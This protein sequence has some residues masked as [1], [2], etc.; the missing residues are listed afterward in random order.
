MS[1]ELRTPLNAVIGFSEMME[2]QLLG[3]LGNDKYL[4]YVSGIRKSGEHLLSLISDILDMSKIEA[5]KYDLSLESFNLSKSARLAVHMIEGRALNENVKVIINLQSEDLNIVADRRAV[6]QVMLNLLSNAVKFSNKGGEVTLDV[7]QNNDYT[8]IEASDSG[9]GI[10]A[11]KLASI[12]EP[13]EQAEGHLSREYEGTGLGLSITKELV[14][15]HG[16]DIN[17]ISTVGVGTEVLVK[18]PNKTEV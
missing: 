2:H 17:L 10:P 9:I 1:H 11:N 18:L 7:K 16:G 12:M 6:M 14:E 8:Y 15:I 13:F 4:E 3:P 5:G